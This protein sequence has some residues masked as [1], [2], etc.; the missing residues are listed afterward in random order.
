MSGNA[1]ARAADFCD[2]SLPRL[3]DSPHGYRMRGD[4]CE[5]IFVREVSG[6]ELR[7][8]SCTRWFADFDPASAGSLPIR[9]RAPGAGP[10]R[11]RAQALARRS[12]YRMDTVCEAGSGAWAW[13]TD[14][15]AARGLRRADI[16]IVASMRSSVGDGATQLLLPLQ[17][18]ARPPHDAPQRLELVVV[19]QIEL[20]QLFVRVEALRADGQPR[21]ATPQAAVEA[22]HGYYPAERPIRLAIDPPGSGLHRGELGA[23]FK[24]GG[25]STLHFQFHHAGW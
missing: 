13:P 23:V 24:A 1:A 4:R 9:W 20:A 8:V 16:G 10:L 18:G 14:L 11:L 6:E 12:Y 17:V 3:N 22:G 15:L 25:S 5:G 2:P 19:P 21:L 7:L